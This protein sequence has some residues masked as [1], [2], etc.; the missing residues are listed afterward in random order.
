MIK[1]SDPEVQQYQEYR[2]VLDK[3]KH[4]PQVDGTNNEDV[5][6]MIKGAMKVFKHKHT[7]KQINRIISNYIDSL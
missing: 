2:A 5:K 1:S 7:E 4:E 3:L 6:D